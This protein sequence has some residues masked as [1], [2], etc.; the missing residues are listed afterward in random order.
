MSGVVATDEGD[1]IL[2]QIEGPRLLRA[3]LKRVLG[4][5][6][7]VRDLDDGTW[8]ISHSAWQAACDI[9]W[10]F[11]LSVSWTPSDAA[12]EADTPPPPPALTEPMWRPDVPEQKERVTMDERTTDV[13]QRVADDRQ[14]VEAEVEGLRA[15]IAERERRLSEIDG[16]LEMYDRYAGKSRTFAY[17][18][19]NGTSES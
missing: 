9:F 6:E 17:A 2:A 16:F 13:R 19:A 5:S 15:Q 11:D 10:R 4:T 18:G 7:A 3:E 1:W 12:E 14:A 8:R